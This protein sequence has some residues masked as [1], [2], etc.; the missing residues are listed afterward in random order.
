[1]NYNKR[2]LSNAKRGF[3]KG[4]AE[5]LDVLVDIDNGN[6][7]NGEPYIDEDGNELRLDLDADENGV[8]IVNLSIRQRNTNMTV[9]ITGP[10][11][12]VAKDLGESTF[13]KR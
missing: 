3:I 8:A 1:M 11:E 12:D 6:G 13:L 10:I 4:C 2:V 7:S 5:L 9:S